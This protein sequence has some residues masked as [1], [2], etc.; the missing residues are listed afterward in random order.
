MD[1]SEWN[2]EKKRRKDENYKESM[3]VFQQ[4]QELAHKNG[5]EL[6]KHS[7]WHFALSYKPKGFTVWLY[8]LYPSNQRIYNDPNFRGPFLQ[9]QKPWTLLDVVSTAI[10]AAV[11]A[12]ERIVNELEKIMKG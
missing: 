11:P 8:N 4:A 2:A 9:L 7:P 1:W 3:K 10:F 5:F 6:H 12:P